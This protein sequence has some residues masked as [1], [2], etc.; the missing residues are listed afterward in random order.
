[1]AQ[2]LPRYCPR[3]GTPTREDM[4]RC[5]TCELPIEAMLSRSDNQR[6][7]TAD[8]NNAAPQEAVVPTPRQTQLEDET[9][10]APPSTWAQ[11]FQRGW[12][13][14]GEQAHPSQFPPI[15]P[16]P[17]KPGNWHDPDGPGIQQ[18]FPP[19][20]G[21]WNDPNGPGIQ[22]PWSTPAQQ[23]IAEPWNAPGSA[24]PIDNPAIQA[25]WSGQAEPIRPPA[26]APRSPGKL[27]PG[28]I[29]IVLIVLLV[30]IGGGVFAFSA[31]GGHL[32][33]L[34]ASQATI[35][36]TGLNSTVTYAGATITILTVQQ[37]QNFVDDPQT[38]GDGML[39]LNLQEQNPTNVPITWNYTQSARLISQGKAAS[40]PI[41]VRAKG[42][43]APGATQKSVVDFAVANGGNLSTL[44]FQ[45]GT[46]KEAQI[47]IPLT[48]QAN[49]SQYQPK[50]TTQNGTLSYFGLNWTLTG[51]T[52]SLSIPAQQASS[53]MEFITLNL[54]TDNTLSQQVI[55]G[56]P[57]EYLRIKIGGQTIAPVST[58]VPVSF[59]PGAMGQ[60]GI[61]TFLVPQNSTTCTLLMLS[62]D[63]GTSGQAKLDF[64]IG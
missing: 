49:L 10:Y 48:G 56:S 28:R 31:L 30:L 43:I 59:A 24:Y 5:A 41:Y 39:R 62:Q 38:A 21:N 2:A 29:F 61:A 14:P 64:Q 44:L 13:S 4:Q 9:Q 19:A 3:C 27:R 51:A 26:Q 32:P 20:P 25:P 36:T 33:G 15:S 23:P 60:K 50:T 11:D 47:H 42:S 1:M 18:P 45:L 12:S 40:L 53:G 17:S 35:K 16:L 7:G 8:Y 55:S 54:T 58:T 22:Q 46:G 63:P 37:A 34:K 6:F 52:T 57:F